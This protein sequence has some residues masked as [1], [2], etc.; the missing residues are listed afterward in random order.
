[1]EHDVFKVT[2]TLAQVATCPQT[3]RFRKE[4]Q[5]VTIARFCATL[6]IC[7]V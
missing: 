1:L 4:K 3:Q 6:C 7:S 2:S 5:V